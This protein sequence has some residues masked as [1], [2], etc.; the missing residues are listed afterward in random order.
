L[1]VR[2]DRVLVDQT[3]PGGSTLPLY[4]TR[5]FSQCHSACASGDAAAAGP[6]RCLTLAVALPERHKRRAF[7]LK[8]PP[9]WI[10]RGI[11]EAVVGCPV[12]ASDVLSALRP[13]NAA[14][15]DLMHSD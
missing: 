11:D 15:P 5:P 12:D 9:S 2:H 7:L 8:S 1:D 10:G 14:T 13:P 3:A 4:R 6:V